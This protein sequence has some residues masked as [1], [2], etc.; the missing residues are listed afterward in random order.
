MARK[1]T[2]VKRSRETGDEKNPVAKSNKK[3]RKK[4]AGQSKAAYGRYDRDFSHVQ[5]PPSTRVEDV[6]EP[7]S[8]SQVKTARYEIR[9]TEQQL[10]IMEKASGILGYKNATDYIRHVMQENAAKVIKD[11]VILQIAEQDRQRFMDELASPGKPGE[12]FMKGVETFN[13]TFKDQ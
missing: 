5:S 2:I 6:T 7:T 11:Q 13:R 4:R 3:Q 10:E 8:R 12:A 9:F 1:A